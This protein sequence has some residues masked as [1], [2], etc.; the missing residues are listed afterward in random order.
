MNNFFI[1]SL[2]YL[3]L[4]LFHNSS[5]FLKT[6]HLTYSSRIQNSPKTYFYE[7]KWLSQNV[8]YHTFLDV[9]YLL[10]FK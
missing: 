4:L 7:V 1:V 6:N 10:E 5:S 2:F 3:I 9:Y 8:G